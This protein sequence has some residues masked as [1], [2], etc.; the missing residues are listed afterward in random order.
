MQHFIPPPPPTPSSP[1]PTPSPLEWCNHRDS[2]IRRVSSQKENML[3]GEGGGAACLLVRTPAPETGAILNWKRKRK[4]A[5]GYSLCCRST[6]TRDY[7]YL[8]LLGGTKT[9]DRYV[10]YIGG[11]GDFNSAKKLQKTP[12]AVHGLYC[13]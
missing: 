9:N 12:S 13:P 8:S 3:G 1:T 5:W 2:G 11:G 4:G 7:Y 6:D 10:L